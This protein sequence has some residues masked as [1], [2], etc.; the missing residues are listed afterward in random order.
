V[1]SDYTPVQIADPRGGG[2]TI[3]VYNLAPSKLGQTNIV[4]MTSDNKIFWNG[5]DLSA[6][7]RIKAVTVFTAG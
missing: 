3:T 2:Q 5:I 7:G 1:N 6:S 4:D